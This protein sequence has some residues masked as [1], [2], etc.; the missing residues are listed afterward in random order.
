MS[1]PDAY[2]LKREWVE[3][4]FKA[5]NRP[6]NTGFY[7][8]TP[9]AGEH[10]YEPEDKNAA[11]D[12]AGLVVDYDDRTGEV[13]VQQRNHFRPGQEVEF[14][15]PGGT[16]FKQT[17]PAIFDEDGNPLDAARHPLQPVR[18]KAERPLK[19]WDMMRKKS[20]FHT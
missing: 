12:F 16:L 5:A 1:D 10:I 19:K 7:F 9:G 6:L 3:E 13:L 11:Y 14:F 2:E 15:G 18:F 8:R 20:H 17:V 4:I